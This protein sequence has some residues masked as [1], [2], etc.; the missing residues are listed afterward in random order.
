MDNIKIDHGEVRFCG[1]NW[2]DLAQ[3]REE[4]RALVTTVMNL[5]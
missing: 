2:T 1:M 3:D 5:A 4:W